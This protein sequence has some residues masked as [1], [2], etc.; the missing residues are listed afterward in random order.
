[1]AEP[2]A[3]RH[4]G[5][6]VL[7]TGA[8]SGNGRATALR[9]AAEGARVA[10]CDLRATPR[11]GG[12]DES[13]ELAIHE[14]IGARGGEAA[15]VECDVADEASVES[16]IST[17]W[18][19]FGGLDGCV[20]NAG[21]FLRTVSILDETTPEHDQIMRV[22]ERGVWL[23]IRGVGRRLVNAGKPGRIVCIASISGLVGLQGEPAYCA[24]KAAVINLTRAAALDLAAHEITVNAI[25]PGFIATAMLREDLDDPQRRAELEAAT[26]WPRLGTAEDVAA[27]ASF[28]LSDDAAWITGAMLAV[29]GGYSCQ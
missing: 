25:C 9:L 6:A 5:R 13:G 12:F 22:N 20:L 29:D 24:S 27:A 26:P 11:P 17:A 18:E 19:L 28:L 21:I 15:F 7:V 16:A 4:E 14:L 8:S 1:M 10:C 2:L 3:Q 23:G